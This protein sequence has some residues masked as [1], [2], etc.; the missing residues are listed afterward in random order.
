[1]LNTRLI[2]SKNHVGNPC[3]WYGCRELV[4]LIPTNGW[5]ATGRISLCSYFS[6]LPAE[7]NQLFFTKCMSGSDRFFKSHSSVSDWQENIFITPDVFLVFYPERSSWSWSNLGCGDEFRQGPTSTSGEMFIGVGN[8]LEQA[9]SILGLA[10]Y[11]SLPA[12][13]IG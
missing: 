12:I 7:L 4:T 13:S 10:V 2:D 11:T 1:M 5:T 9:S 6:S 8:W 3:V